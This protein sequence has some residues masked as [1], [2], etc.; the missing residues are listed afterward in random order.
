MPEESLIVRLDAKTQ[1]LDA[2]LQSTNEKLDKLTDTTERTDSKFKKFTESAKVAAVAV[3]AVAAATAALITQ[4][5]Q[6][7]KELQIAS[8]RNG[9]NVERMQQWAFAANTVGVSLEKL[10]DIGKDTNE[11]VSEFISTGG[12]GFQDFADVMGLT[13]TQAKELAKEFEEMS[14]T[15]VLQE[16]VKRMEE[17]GISAGQMSFALEGMASDTTDLIPL[18]K[19][20]SAA[21][22][23]LTDDFDALGVS[24]TQ[25][26]INKITAVGVEFDKMTAKLSGESKQAVA[27]YAEE[28][29][30]AIK[31]TTEFLTTTGNV[32]AVIATGWGNILEISQAAVTDMVNGTDTLSGVLNERAKLTSEA[33]DKLVTDVK[34]GAK[35]IGED[36]VI[37]SATGGD[38]SAIGGGGTDD[39]ES[40]TIQKINRE[41]EAIKDRFKTEE[42][43]LLKKFEL[44]KALLDVEVE[45]IE[46]R[47]ALKLELEAEFQENL[48]E[49]EL[50]AEEKKQKALDKQ[51]KDRD[52]LQKE[53]DKQQ[54]IDKKIGEDN[55]KRDKDN[56]DAAISIASMV[57]ED[58]KAVS[59]GIA[60]VNTARAITEVLPNY[61]MAAAVAVSGALQVSAI[62]GASK[63][64][65]ST[66]SVGSAPAT[67]GTQGA[68]AVET[69]SLELTTQD[70]DSVTTTTN[71]FAVDSG[72]ELLDMLA[73]LL[74]E[75]ERNGR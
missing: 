47:N 58:S 13:A 36:L 38:A 20:G 24:L 64:G 41:V 14:G 68:E 46:E 61:A 54:K 7:A 31:V 74:N 55:V 50:K 39:E 57:F 10:G 35:S 63:G 43:L 42:E 11:K 48:T 12:G 37:P 28:I 15:D 30:T 22:K 49:I 19:D 65:G 51:K 26:D 73:G 23:T 45:N 60:V 40:P 25:E 62:L 8:T 2:K 33:I 52:K 34:D 4:T 67:S 29:A 5:V 75:R 32:F 44:E 1:A 18:L 9:E 16:M 21:L 71:N 53:K 6:Y 3:T 59:A 72:D 27:E 70:A 56:A 69:S 66:A 17:G